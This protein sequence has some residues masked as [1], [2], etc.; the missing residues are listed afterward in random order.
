MKAVIDRFEEEFAVLLFGDNE[1]KVNIPKVLLPADA[2]EGTIFNVSFEI[3]KKSEENQ[4]QKVQ[5]LLDKL[6]SKEGW[7]RLLSLFSAF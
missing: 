5:S 3:D 1:V 7:V 4:K 2:K 6:K